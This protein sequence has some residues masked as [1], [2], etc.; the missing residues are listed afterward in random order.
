MENCGHR[1]TL[2]ENSAFKSLC[3][4]AKQAK[5][6]SCTVNFFGN[7]KAGRTVVLPVRLFSFSTKV[8]GARVALKLTIF[9]KKTACLNK[10]LQHCFSKVACS[11]AWSF[12][13]SC[14]EVLEC[15]V[16]MRTDWHCMEKVQLVHQCCH[17]ISCLGQ[18]LAM[19]I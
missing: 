3:V 12:Q 15:L 13:C 8:V 1:M 11:L 14:F 18:N 17:C 16:C 5:H 4:I 9:L 10:R 6:P 19:G 2:I 7:C